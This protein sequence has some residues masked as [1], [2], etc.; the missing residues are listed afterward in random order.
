MRIRLLVGV[1]G[2]IAAY[3]ALETARLAVRAGHAVRV[4]Q[5]RNS[6]RFVGKASFAAI[7]GA[8]V[9]SSEF[10]ADPARGAYPGDDV[11]AHAP[12][13]HLALVQHADAY[14]IAPASADTIAKLA[15]GLADNLLTSAALAATCPVIVAPA[16]NEAMY[17]NAAT[18]ANL[19]TL[20]QRGLIVLAPGEGEL[21][22][23]GEHGV[24]RI[25][26]P[27]ALLAAVEA[28]A[29]ARRAQAASGERSS[30]RRAGGT[31]AGRR[32]LVTAGGTREPIDSVRYIGNRSSG[33]MGLALAAAAGAR[34][35]VV[36]CV[37]ANV[38][39]EPPPVARVRRVQTAAEL[40]AAC[41]EEFPAHDLLL[42]AAAVA[43]FRPV[44]AA[45]GKLTKTGPEAPHRIELEAT[46]DVLEALSSLRAPGQVLVG[47][48]AEHGAGGLERA[49]A[50]LRRKQ[51]DAIVVNDVARE[52]IGFDSEYNEA[53]LITRA[54]DDVPLP[55]LAKRELAELILDRVSQLPA[56]AEL[57]ADSLP[58]GAGVG[59]G[60]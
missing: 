26:E 36:T 44:G 4:I 18:Q 52:D 11:P 57:S 23:H 3:K 54:G 58:A 30:E 7:T 53:T 42:M 55:R 37:L 1:C 48:A 16:M 14:L 6:L 15:V 49:R 59:A 60:G 41:R 43:D 33:R 45:T 22:S 46:E 51:L 8:P 56:A 27:A 39:L 25:P 9:L 35:A 17:L 50:K 40:A 29:G 24:G 13:S 32:V 10:E 2:G 19:V 20:R 12:I 28:A 5:T 31:L 34:G 21:A 47:F 38:A